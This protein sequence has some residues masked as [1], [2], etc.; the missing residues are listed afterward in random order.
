MREKFHFR[1]PLRKSFSPNKSGFFLVF[2]YHCFLPMILNHYPEI[3]FR[4]F[5]TF[6]FFIIAPNILKTSK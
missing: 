2:Y 4:Y 6:A 1:N 3:L 5:L